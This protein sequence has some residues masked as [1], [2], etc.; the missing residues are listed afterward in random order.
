MAGAPAGMPRGSMP[1]LLKQFLKYDNYNIGVIDKFP[2][3]TI[4]Y[5]FVFWDLVRSLWHSRTFEKSKFEG[6]MIDS[7][8]I[9]EN[10]ENPKTI[11]I[12]IKGYINFSEDL[13][14]IFSSLFNFF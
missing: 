7:V 1:S 3:F 11:E 2:K 4:R 12:F 13:A 14:I 8:F 6:S 5:I 9:E 10:F